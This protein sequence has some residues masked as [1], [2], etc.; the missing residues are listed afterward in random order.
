MTEQAKKQKRLRLS[1]EERQER[2]LDATADF[3]RENGVS[4]LSMDRL[5]RESG[6]S[7]PLIYAYFN[8]RIG[9][10]KALLLREAARRQEM[11]REAVSS[12]KT[13]EELIRLTA[14]ALLQHA[15]EAGSI[16]QQLLIEPEVAEVLS[17]VREETG[18]TYIAY[19]SKRMGEHYD[20]ASEHAPAIVESVLGIGTAAG[21][22]FRRG[23]IDLDQ[24]E[25]IMVTLT[26]GALEAAAKKF[27]A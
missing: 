9:L 11:D 17:E 6:H 18:Q 22:H 5:A 7:K 14:R 15:A 25:E 13:I 24:M 21:T 27:P 2:I 10:L 1:P 16:I 8:S 26:T 12:A 23:D 4:A 19:L 20:I 3:I